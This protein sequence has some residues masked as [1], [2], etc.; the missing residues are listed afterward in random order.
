MVCLGPH[1]SNLFVTLYGYNVV[2]FPILN[3]VSVALYT[4]IFKHSTFLVNHA[5]NNKVM[6]CLTY[7]RSLNCNNGLTKQLI[8]MYVLTHNV[9]KRLHHLLR[10]TQAIFWD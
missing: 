9:F 5:D 3:D 1:T 7:V 10:M 4:S 8:I 2:C 6:N